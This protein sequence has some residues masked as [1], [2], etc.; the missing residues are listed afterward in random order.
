MAAAGGR[1]SRSWLRVSLESPESLRPS[2]SLRSVARIPGPP[3]LV[4]MAIPSD[5]G[6]GCSVKA[7]P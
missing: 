2:F 5:L 7:R 1:Y 3:A 6:A 4:T